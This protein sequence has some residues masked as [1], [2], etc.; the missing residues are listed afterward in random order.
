[1]GLLCYFYYPKYEKASS[2]KKQWA[3]IARITIPAVIFLYLIMLIPDSHYKIPNGGG[4]EPFEWKQDA[5]WTD[6][7]TQFIADRVKSHDDLKSHIANDLLCG[8]LLCDSISRDSL[9]PE[10]PI[11]LDLENII[12]ELAP[13]VGACPDQFN[14]YESLVSKMRQIVKMQSRHW[15]MNSTTARQRVYRLLYGSREALEEILLQ[16]P[17]DSIS[18]LT[19]GIDETSATPSTRVLGVTIHSGDI[20]VSR[21]G[22]PTSALIARGN[23]YPGN[24]S[25]IALV[26]VDDKTSLASINE[27]HIERGVVISSLEEYLRDKKL[28]VMVLRLRSG[29]PE[30]KA[31]PMLPHKVASLAMKQVQAQHI[32][33]DFEMDFQNHSKEFCSEVASAPYSQFGIHLWM[34]KSTISSPGLVSWLAAFGV[35]NFE[36]QEPSDLEYDPQLQVVA[37]W[38]DPETLYK[39]HVDNAVIDIML[40]GADAGDRLDYQWYLLP[41]ARI[42]KVYSV[43][44]NWFG[45]I[46]PVPEGMNATAALRNQ[47]FSSRHLQQKY[48]S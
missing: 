8:Q 27:A 28:R 44:L 29:L 42:L 16:M 13:M 47:Q 41:M 33:Y 19:L 40:E 36:T 46:G 20:L 18:P 3:K 17:G 11:F 25:H 31:D 23:D 45:G 6:L 2:M 15:D 9:S 30:I 10:A 12:F 4:K 1:M 21:G 39:D 22:A 26:Y 5:Q 35:K 37:E 32:P 7:E 48:Y 38:R 43:I 34:G 14:A 24:F